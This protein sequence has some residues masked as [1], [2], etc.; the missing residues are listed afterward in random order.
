[1]TRRE[2]YKKQL[3]ELE[4]RRGRLLRA[5]RYLEAQDLHAD[6]HRIERMIE[7]ADA[8]EEACRPRPIREIV[9][10]EELQEMGIIPLMIETH[11][12]ADFLTAIAYEVVD[13]CEAHGLRDVTLMPELEKLIRQSEKF[14]SFL[15]SLGP[16]LRELMLR[17]EN[18]NESIHGKYKRYIE[19]RL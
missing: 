7:E 10:R 11:L 6:I 14:A 13:R 1:M 17:N 15:T 3:N 12:A 9:S 4:G 16:E 5:G 19:Q 2:R 8:Y 18:L